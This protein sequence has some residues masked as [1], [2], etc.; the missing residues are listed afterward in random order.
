M[1]E[2]TALKHPTT[3]LNSSFYHELGAAS[4]S[5]KSRDVTGLIL[6]QHTFAK[7]KYGQRLSLKWL[8]WVYVVF[9]IRALIGFKV[10]MTGL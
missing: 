7:I 2:T 8:A 5:T 6:E 4:V 9:L 1:F 3:F 10:R